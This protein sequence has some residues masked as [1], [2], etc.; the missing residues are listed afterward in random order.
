LPGED[1]SSRSGSGRQLLRRFSFLRQHSD[2]NRA[3]PG[4]TL[5][6]IKRNGRDLC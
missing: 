1:F 3:N 4:I 5:V 2:L 6:V